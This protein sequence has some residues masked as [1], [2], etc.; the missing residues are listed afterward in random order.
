MQ[1]WSQPLLW[2]GGVATP[3]DPSWLNVVLLMGY[4]DVNGSTGAPGMN[5]ESPHAHGTGGISGTALI[6]TSQFKFGTSSLRVNAGDVAFADSGDWVLSSANSDQFTVECWIRLAALGSYQFIAQAFTDGTSSWVFSTGSSNTEIGLTYYPSGTFASAVSTSTTGA[7][8][9]I[10]TWYHVAVDKDATGKIRLYVNGVMKG[11][12]TP[13]NSAFYDSTWSLTIG[14]NFGGG[15]STNGWID[16]LRITKGA[17]R[18]ATDTSFPVPTAA[19]PR[20]A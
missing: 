9:V 16:E 10:N 4:E 6:D 8:L 3:G 2:Q 7:G 14:Q 13:A 11:S 5:D 19:F 12:A 17:A 1:P 15:G 18:Y 20:H